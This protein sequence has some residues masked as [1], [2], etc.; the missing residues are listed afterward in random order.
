MS[1]RTPDSI[2]PKGYDKNNRNLILS[3][4][5]GEKIIL[6]LFSNRHSNT[7]ELVVNRF[8]NQFPSPWTLTSHYCCP[9]QGPWPPSDVI[10]GSG[11]TDSPKS[12][13][14]GATSAFNP[15]RQSGTPHLFLMFLLICIMKGLIMLMRRP[16][17]LVLSVGDTA[18]GLRAKS[19]AKCVT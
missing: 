5:K 1:T 6:F 10:S 19:C 14:R 16:S 15:A 18:V 7:W 2:P 4:A 13:K 3:S 17:G 11:E 8:L 12:A 9:F